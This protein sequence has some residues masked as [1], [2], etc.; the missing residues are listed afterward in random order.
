MSLLDIKRRFVAISY[1]HQ[2]S[3]LGSC[4]STLPILYNI[5]QHHPDDVVILSN[6]HAGLAQYC[7]L[8]HFFGINAEEM[9]NKHGIHPCYDPDNRIYCSTG[10][11][12]LGLPVAIGYALAGRST[13]CIISDGECA[14]GS[15][16]ESLSFI[17]EF[18]VPIQVYVNVNGFG[19]YRLVDKEKL[20]K[21]L[22]AFYPAIHICHTSNAPFP[23]DLWAH[24]EVMTEATKEVYEKNLG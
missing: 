1:K 8:E 23:D 10:S 24:Y 15:I 6:G 3:H 22:L 20:S 13:H 21:R 9:L 14:E 2:L 5:Y 18:K 19:A 7:C 12:G 17:E 16:W 4:I 11:L